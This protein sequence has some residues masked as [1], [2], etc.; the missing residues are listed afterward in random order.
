M[1]LTKPVWTG[2]VARVRRGRHTDTGLRH[3]QRQTQD[4]KRERL[5][6]VKVV[7]PYLS[8]SHSETYACVDVQRWCTLCIPI[9]IHQSESPPTTHI[10]YLYSPI[11]QYRTLHSHHI[12]LTTIYVSMRQWGRAVCTLS[13][14]CALSTSP[15]LHV[16]SSFYRSE[17]FWG[18]W[19][20]PNDTLLLFRVSYA[21][22]ALYQIQVTMKIFSPALCSAALRAR[23]KRHLILPST[24]GSLRKFQQNQRGVLLTDCSLLLCNQRS[25][26]R[27]LP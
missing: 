26:T 8:P 27:P 10:T 4:N 13:R 7:R 5:F 9:H 19:C 23:I 11:W 16:T 3:K 12:G 24:A 14:R 2:H 17:V 21:L 20:A 22:W 6:T 1:C 18:E 15:A 25:A